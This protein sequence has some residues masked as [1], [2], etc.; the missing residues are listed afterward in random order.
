M[1]FKQIGLLII[2]VLSVFVVSG[3]S[4]LPRVTFDKAGVTPTQT[5]KSVKKESCSGE[6]KLNEEG[7][8]VS[9]SKGY[10][11]YEQN[12]SQKERAYTWK[13]K[14]LNFIRNLAGVWFWLLIAV[15]F[16]VP[17]ALG[18]L[19][20]G[21]FNVA[22][23]ALTS[24]IKAISKFKSEI[25]TVVINDVEVPDPTYVKAVDALLDDL[26]IAHAQNVDVMKTIA[27]IRLQLKIKDND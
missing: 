2:L 24:T 9:C 16:L 13:E 17:G 4:I 5:D 26:E 8:I 18:W 6:Y 15:I 11:N 27:K 25:P 20:S 10:Y 3:C 14:M 22:K 7:Y 19:I 1:K 23:T 21:F 12:Y